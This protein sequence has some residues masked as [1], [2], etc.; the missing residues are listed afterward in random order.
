MRGGAIACVEAA[1]HQLEH[2]KNQHQRQ[3]KPADDQAHHLAALLFLLLILGHGAVG[4]AHRCHLVGGQRLG[5][6]LAH[7]G[8]LQILPDIVH[9]H[10]RVLAELL[11]IVQHGV[12][13]LITLGDVRAHGLHA[14]Q[15]QSLGDIR[16]QLPGGLGNSA[17]MLDSHGH[18]GVTLEGQF[19][20]EH[21]V[22]HHT[23]GINVRAS[24]HPVAAGLFGR[25]VM[26]GAQ[27]L[28]GQG[29]PLVC[30]TCDA[31]I[32]HSDASIPQ[33]HD[34]LGLDVPVDHAA[35]V[36]M[37]EAAHDL[38]DKVQRFPP[39]H[40]APALH[41]LLQRHAVDELHNDVIDVI[42]AR[43][44]V[45]RHD[46]GVGQL[47]HS[48]GLI[49]EPAAEIGVLGQVTVQDLYRYQP[50]QP[51]ALGLIDV[52]HASPADQLQYLIAIIQHFPNVRIHIVNS[53]FSRS[54]AG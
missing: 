27:G 52:G 32:G 40:L 8:G 35:A 29:L 24:V 19:A 9:I 14:D 39:V 21:L 33:D 25:N 18:G 13:G 43:H 11:Q 48:P 30:Q 53:S 42:T 15:L 10:G 7:H 49:H 5:G 16:I 6:L 1:G 26:H 22:Q 34:V 20:G 37:A 3:G 4:L 12:S 38:G 17:Q 46:V 44:V 23:G 31:E 51:V 41:I 2:H 54:S 47:G 45:N 50:V 36:G 28:L